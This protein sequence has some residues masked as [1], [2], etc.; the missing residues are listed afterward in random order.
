MT[1]E[2]PVTVSPKLP[3]PDCLTFMCLCIS[4][5]ELRSA[6][7]L[8][9]D[10]VADGRRGAQLRLMGTFSVIFFLSSNQAVLFRLSL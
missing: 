1:F 5:L 4:W 2:P 8:V 7:F 6:L 9:F 3:W 10:G